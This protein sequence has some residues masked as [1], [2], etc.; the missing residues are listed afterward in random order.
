MK[1][2]RRFLQ[3]LLFINFIVGIHGGMK[4]KNLVLILVN[5]VLVLA[6]IIREVRR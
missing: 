1:K 2:A 3:I 4:A 6:V 5:G